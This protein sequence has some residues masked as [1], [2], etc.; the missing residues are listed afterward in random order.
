MPGGYHPP[1]PIL[2]TWVVTSKANSTIAPPTAF[3]ARNHL[4]SV[5]KPHEEGE[6]QEDVQLM[7][8]FQ[9]YANRVNWLDC[10][11]CGSIQ[12]RPQVERLKP[13]NYKLILSPL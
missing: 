10:L 2:Y 5:A 9:K 13:S 1:W 4:Q 11:E 6:R 8:Y 7:G 12:K 3:L